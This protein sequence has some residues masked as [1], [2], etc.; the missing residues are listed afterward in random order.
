MPQQGTDKGKGKDSSKDKGTDKGKGRGKDKTKDKGD[1]HKGEGYGK[2]HKN[3]NS[4]KS[5][6]YQNSYP[7][8]PTQLVTVKNGLHLIDPNDTGDWYYNWE[9]G[10]RQYWSRMWNGWIRGTYEEERLS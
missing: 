10:C 4:Y 8:I 7:N 2:S 9:Q 6:P 3:K 1:T 5:E